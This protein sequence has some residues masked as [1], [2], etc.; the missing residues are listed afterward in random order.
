MARTLPAS[1]RHCRGNYG[2]QEAFGLS[3]G[4][5][6]RSIQAV[7]EL[8][9]PVKPAKITFDELVSVLT[10]HYSPPPSEIVQQFRFHT[11]VRKPRESVAT[12][13]V[14][15]RGLSELCNFDNS[16]EKMLSDQ[17]V[18]RINDPAIQKRLLAEP[19]LNFNKALALAHGL[20][21]AAKVVD[22][23]KGSQSSGTLPIKTQPVNSVQQNEPPKGPV[24]CS[25]CGVQGH[26]A[27]ACKHRDKVCHKC[28]KQGH[29]ARVCNSSKTTP[30]KPATPQTGKH[31]T[32]R[33]KRLDY[34][35]A[36]SEDSGSALEEGDPIH[37]VGREKGGERSPPI[38]VHVMLDG[39]DVSMEV[40][41]GASVS[42]MSEASFQNLWPGI[43]GALRA[44]G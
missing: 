43:R 28:N 31:S 10:K 21:T 44:V 5:W 33:P 29:L 19:D 9:G 20:E 13:V 40:D 3:C 15:L 7:T 42:L 6:T 22:E 18:C 17:L 34:V 41:T 16:L 2:E 12:F 14:E 11:R 36:E 27:T 35:D 24:T 25:R 30:A 4:Y 39:K 1:Q 26:L 32:R 8:P 23:L 38:T 37:A